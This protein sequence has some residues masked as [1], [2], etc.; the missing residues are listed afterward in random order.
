MKIVFVTVGTT[1]FEHLIETILSDNILDILKEQNFNKIILQIGNGNHQ[2]QNLQNISREKNAAVTFKKKNLEI[3]AYRYKNT[4]K[5]DLNKADLVI[6]HAGSGSIIESLE[7]NK[8]LVVVCNQDLMDNHQFELAE[9][10][11]K[12]DYLLYT[13]CSSLHSTL[14][15]LKNPHLKF[16]RYQPGNPRLF[17]NHLNKICLQ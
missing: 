7:A 13:T 17:G 11:A 4:L 2:D 3:E 10:M 15:L 1:K 9:K 14:G 16:K 8:K 12:L 5:D 6:S